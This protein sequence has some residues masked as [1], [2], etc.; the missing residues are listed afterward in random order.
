MGDMRTGRP[1][2]RRALTHELLDL[3]WTEDAAILPGTGWVEQ[4]AGRART[5][6]VRSLLSPGARSSDRFR[7]CSP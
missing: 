6:P 1:D 7:L 3:D 2:V 5:V 4:H